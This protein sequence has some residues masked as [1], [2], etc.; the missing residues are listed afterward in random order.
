MPF[1]DV[2]TTS[3]RKMTPTRALKAWENT[4]GICVTCERLIDGTKE[5]WFVEHKRALELGGA[6]DDAN[7]GPAH[8]DTCKKVKDADDHSRASQ[9]KRQKRI[10]LGIKLKEG[11]RLPG[12]RT[13]DYKLTLNRG[14]QPRHAAPKKEMPARAKPLYEE[15]G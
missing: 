15:V 10:Q 6:D 1:I 14:V 9:A 8:F 5:Q 13:D 2:P 7:I 11:P 12:C 3:R 4:G